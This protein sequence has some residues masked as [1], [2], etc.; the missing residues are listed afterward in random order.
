MEVW[1]YTWRPEEGVRSPGAVVTGNYLTWAIG[2][3]L[4]F[5][6]KSASVLNF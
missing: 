6:A 3:K 5:S 1:V 4:R 2:S